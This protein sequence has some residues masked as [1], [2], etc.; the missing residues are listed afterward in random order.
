[1]KTITENITR[2]LRVTV[3]ERYNEV[4][5]VD[6]HFCEVSIVGYDWEQAGYTW[7]KDVEPVIA[8]V[9][10]DG[11]RR[12]ITMTREK[13]TTLFSSGTS[14]QMVDRLNGGYSE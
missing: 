1:M 13:T 4:H 6:E 7:E 2:T 14:E 8:L 10:N 5:V 9:A 12:E 11:Q 3:N